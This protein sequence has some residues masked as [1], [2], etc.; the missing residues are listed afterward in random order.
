[1]KCLES[2]NWIERAS[3]AET[4]GVVCQQLDRKKRHWVVRNLKHTLQDQESSVQQSGMIAYER[5]GR[6]SRPA[7]PAV[8]SLLDTS[9]IHVKS[10]GFATL[11]AISDAHDQVLPTLIA[12]V[13]SPDSYFALRAIA[14]MQD[15]ARPAI[16][17]LL[18]CVTP[19]N[20]N[21]RFASSAL[22]SAGVRETDR[23]AEAIERISAAHLSAKDPEE[24]V[25]GV[26]LLAKLLPEARFMRQKIE[27]LRG[28]SDRLDQA[29]MNFSNT[30]G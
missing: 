20:S 16:P 29:I 25:I 26:L 6:D 14:R 18:K 28:V 7:A 15:G 27:T 13:D 12:K 24:Q 9:A 2:D 23:V 5:I 30:C 3:V 21:S 4:L 19:E 17:K 1:M 10:Q 22:V 11:G 8:I